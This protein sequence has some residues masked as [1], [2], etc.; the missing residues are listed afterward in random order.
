MYSFYIY[1]R[2]RICYDYHSKVHAI[3]PALKFNIIVAALRQNA[4]NS[5]HVTYTSLDDPENVA[6]YNCLPIH[7]LSK[8]YF[9]NE[10]GHVDL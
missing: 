2:A 8:G 5:T 10:G 4:L 7:A 3:D 9:L 6:M 1:I